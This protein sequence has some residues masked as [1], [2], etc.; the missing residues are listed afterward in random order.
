MSDEVEGQ[1]VIDH[2]GITAEQIAAL[3]PGTPAGQ[4][5]VDGLRKSGWVVAEPG[6]PYVKTTRLPDGSEHLLEVA[7][8]AADVIDLLESFGYTVGTYTPRS[9]RGL[10][11]PPRKAG[12]R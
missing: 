1:T 8:S 2:P 10:T 6:R 7:G 11:R 12:D 5:L 3:R 4:R 9:L